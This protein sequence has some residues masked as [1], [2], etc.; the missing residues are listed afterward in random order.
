[1]ADNRGIKQFMVWLP[2]NL[3]TDLHVEAGYQQ[4]SVAEI[5][6]RACREYLMI[7]AQDRGRSV[8]QETT[9]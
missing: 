4:T 5:I 2:V 9:E 3:L 7:H 6:R 1:M 8:Q